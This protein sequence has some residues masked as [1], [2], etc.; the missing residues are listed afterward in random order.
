MNHFLD[1]L[2]VGTAQLGLKYGINNSEDMPNEHKAFGLL[3][4]CQELGI[5]KLDTSE[6]YGDSHAKIK[7]STAAGLK[8]QIYT[9]FV[10]KT[11]DSLLSAANRILLELDRQS[12]ECISFHRFDDYL[13]FPSGNE[14]LALKQQG[15]IKKLGVSVYGESEIEK[16]LRDPHVDVVQFPF[17][18]LD[19]SAE[20]IKLLGSLKANQK[21][22]HIRSAFLQGLFMKPLDD[23]P[24]HLAALKKPVQDLHLIAQELNLSL[25]ALA[26]AFPFS[27][28]EIDG[29]IIG[30]DSAPQI[31]ENVQALQAAKLPSDLLQKLQAI[32]GYERSLL[33]PATW[34][35]V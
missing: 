3:K 12:V 24:E 21:E 28:S 9:K 33:N 27:L 11:G 4:A 20:K 17:N 25:H 1:R 18:L 29:V 26:L 5:N 22:V 10:L 8:F 19:C 32:T 6:G 23:F 16:V 13:K 35:E 7:H 2:I 15:K 30:L 31:R 14:S 34:A